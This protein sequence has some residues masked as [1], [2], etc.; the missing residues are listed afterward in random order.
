MKKISLLLAALLVGGVS[1]A[2]AATVSDTFGVSIDIAEECFVTVTAA[3]VNFGQVNRS[4]TANTDAASVVSVRCTTGTPWIVGL[5]GGLNSNA[6]TRRMVNGTTFVPYTL[7]RDSARTA[8][9]G[10]TAGTNTAAGTGTGVN[11]EVNVYGRVLGSATNV[12]AGTYRD[13]V[14]ATVTY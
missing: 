9:F 2:F 5:N 7:F 10:D 8:A 1:P 3:N 13:T 6:G 4:I 14:R 12:A 11:Q